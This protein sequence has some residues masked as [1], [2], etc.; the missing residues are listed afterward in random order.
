MPNDEQDSQ[1]LFPPIDE[2]QDRELRIQT[3]PITSGRSPQADPEDPG[4]GGEPAEVFIPQTPQP[5]DPNN[6]KSEY[7]VGTGDCY[8]GEVGYSYDAAIDSVRKQFGIID[9]RRVQPWYDTAGAGALTL[10]EI[11][12]PVSGPNPSLTQATPFPAIDQRAYYAEADDPVLVITGRD[13]RAY[14]LPDNTPFIGIVAQNSE[15]ASTKEAVFG[16]AGNITIK[17]TRQLITGNP[18][19]GFP[20]FTPI[21]AVTY[22]HVYPIADVG[23]HHGYRIGDTVLCFRRGMY[24]FCLPNRGTYHGRIVAAGPNSEA[25]FTDE[26]YW[27]RLTVSNVAFTTTGDPAVGTNTWDWTGADTTLFIVCAANLA[28]IQ[29]GTHKYDVTSVDAIGYREGPHEVLATLF[30]DRTT[31]VPYWIFSLGIDQNVRVS[32]ADYWPGPLRAD[33]SGGPVGAK[34]IGDSEVDI[35]GTTTG[36]HIEITLQQDGETP[37]SVQMVIGHGGPGEIFAT[38]DL[39]VGAVTIHVQVDAKG[40]VVGIYTS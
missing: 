16:G 32:T 35:N 27:V 26:R 39:V 36:E 40:H 15:T 17:V 28:E 9:V 14:Y 2:S 10:G 21:S 22:D 31:G 25:D 20:T 1:S 37:N 30:A 23:Q 18:T 4:A 33:P 3:G 6:L 11:P 24:M 19:T 38:Y 34:I 8:L 12:P 7:I 29:T 5:W 13:G